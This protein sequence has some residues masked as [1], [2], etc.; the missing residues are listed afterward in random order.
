VDRFRIIRRNEHGRVSSEQ[1]VE[2][3][4]TDRLSKHSARLPKHNLFGPMSQM[5]LFDKSLQTPDRANRIAWVL[6]YTSKPASGHAGDSAGLASRPGLRGDADGSLADKVWRT[7]LDLSPVALLEAWR[8]PLMTWCLEK[9]AIAQLGHQAGQSGDPNASLYPVI[10]PV[11]AV[12]V[13][14]SDHFVAHVSA[15]VRDGLLAT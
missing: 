11:T 15:G 12:R 3:S 7:V 5:W 13:S 8:E 4:G 2:V 1:L 14:L 6:Q 9:G 10:G